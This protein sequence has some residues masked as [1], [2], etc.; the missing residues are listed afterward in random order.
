MNGIFPTHTEPIS[1][2]S[3]ELSTFQTLKPY[4]NCRTCPFQIPRTEVTSIADSAQQL[5]GE[6]VSLFSER[7]PSQAVELSHR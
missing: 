1:K 7:I 5:V 3:P 4:D 2:T 6:S